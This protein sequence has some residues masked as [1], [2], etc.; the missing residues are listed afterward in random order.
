M[1]KMV[2]GREEDI[3][4]MLPVDAWLMGLNLILVDPRFYADPVYLIGRHGVIREWEHVPSIGEV[5]DACREAIAKE[6]RR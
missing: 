2:S 6:R 5:D 3:T 1:I 4:K